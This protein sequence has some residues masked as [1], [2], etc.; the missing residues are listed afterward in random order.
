MILTLSKRKLS[1]KAQTIGAIAAIVSAVALPQM[2]HMVGAATGHGTALGEMLLP[3]HLPVIFAGL[4]VG[5]YAAGIA[6]LLSPLISFGITG[7]PTAAMLPFMMIELAMYGV[8]AGVLKDRDISDIAKVLI[9]QIVGRTVRAV[10][11]LIGF[12]GLGTVVAPA[13]ILTSIKIGFVGIVIQL[14]VIPFI[15]RSAKRA[16]NE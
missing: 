6:G 7:M 15:V 9:T 13:V 5:P 12:Y 16:D 14:L 11:I 8:C 4:L 2:I 10:A 3:M 1:I